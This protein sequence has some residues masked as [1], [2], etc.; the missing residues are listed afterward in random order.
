MLDQGEIVDEGSAQEVADNFLQLMLKSDSAGNKDLAGIPRKAGLG[1]EIYFTACVIKNEDGEAVSRLKFGERLHFRLKARCEKSLEDL[2][3]SLNIMTL[4]GVSIF[5]SLSDENGKTFRADKDE[6][7][8]L[9]VKISDIALLPRSYDVTIAIRKSGKLL[10]S[11][12]NACPFS[13]SDIARTEKGQ[14]KVKS[15]MVSVP[16]RWTDEVK[17]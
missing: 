1:R 7:L 2:S 3:F 4:D 14:T 15:G 8:H 10:D 6:E 17:A 16:A 5:T 11:V 12:R 9:S 13:V